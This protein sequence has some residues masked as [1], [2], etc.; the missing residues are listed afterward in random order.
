MNVNS[1]SVLFLRPFLLDYEI[2]SLLHETV[3][4]NTLFDVEPSLNVNV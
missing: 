3:A 4:P 1:C 2:V